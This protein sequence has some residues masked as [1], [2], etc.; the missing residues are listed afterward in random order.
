[1]PCELVPSLPSFS[2]LELHAVAVCAFA[3]LPQAPVHLPPVDFALVLIR[4]QGREHR[5]HHRAAMGWARVVE[6]RPHPLGSP[7]AR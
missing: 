4:W 1:M 6:C 2:P 7:T 3:L 5:S